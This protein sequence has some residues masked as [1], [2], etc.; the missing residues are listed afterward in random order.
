MKRRNIPV[1]CHCPQLN[2][3]IFTEKQ[4]YQKITNKVTD[5]TYTQFKLTNMNCLISFRI[6]SVGF[7]YTA[8]RKQVPI[9]NIK[10]GIV[11]PLLK[12]DLTF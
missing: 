10:L 8:E 5:H 9:I 6:F 3:G 1:Y 7:G 11:T 4:V 12:V 2:I